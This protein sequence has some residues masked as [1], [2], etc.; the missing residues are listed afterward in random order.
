M[1]TSIVCL[2]TVWSQGD[3]ETDLSV[4]PMLDLIAKTQ[5]VKRIHLTCNTQ[6]EFAFNLARCTGYDGYRHLYLSFHGNPGALALADETTMT[7]EDLAALMGD[8]FA[9]WTIHFGSCGT[10][11]IPERRARA[12]LEATGAAMV[13]GYTEAVDWIESAALDLLIMQGVQGHRSMTS[14]WKEFAGRYPDLVR[15]TGLR[16]FTA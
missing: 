8:Q 2:D 16:A 10:L 11:D 5:H 14:F 7:L 12:F 3:L 9:G 6:T 1:T 13:I 15:Y 4:R